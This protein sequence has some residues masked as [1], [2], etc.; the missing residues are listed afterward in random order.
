MVGADIFLTLKNWEMQ[1]CVVC[2]V[3]THALVIMH[4]AI[5]IYNAD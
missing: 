2:A 4:Q 1:W 3:A 5:S